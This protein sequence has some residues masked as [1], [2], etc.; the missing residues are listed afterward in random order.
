MQFIVHVC[1]ATE[2]LL[3]LLGWER[4][5]SAHGKVRK[6]THD[7]AYAE[8]KA[9]VQQRKVPQATTT[10]SSWE[11]ERPKLHMTTVSV[12]G[13]APRRAESSWTPDAFEVGEHTGTV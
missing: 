7:Q 13:P 12:P 11:R 1:S 4:E 5:V 9:S 10:D 6:N 3:L 2:R 8:L